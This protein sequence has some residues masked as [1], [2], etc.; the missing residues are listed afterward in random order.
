ME[1]KA[2]KDSDTLL[3][4]HLNDI[5]KETETETNNLNP[6]PPENARKQRRTITKEMEDLGIFDNVDEE[7]DQEN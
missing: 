1:I 5:L 2:P 6:N 4:S 3:Q 7:K